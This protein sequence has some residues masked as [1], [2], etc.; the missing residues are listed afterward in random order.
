M[1]AEENEYMCNF[2]NLSPLPPELNLVELANESNI[3]FK[4]DLSY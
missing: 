2:P 3:C 4:I 1:E